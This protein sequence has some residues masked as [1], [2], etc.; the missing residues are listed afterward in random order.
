MKKHDFLNLLLQKLSPTSSAPKVDTLKGHFSNV[1]S[2]IFHPKQD[3][4]I[5]NSEDRTIRVWD[6]TKRS[7]IHTFRRENDRFWVITAHPTSNLVAVGHDAGRKF[8]QGR[9]AR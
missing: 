4:I 7:Q 9:T 6:N 2:V 8:S 5:S 1:S 3:L